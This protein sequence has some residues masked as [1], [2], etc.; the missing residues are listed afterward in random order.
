MNDLDAVIERAKLLLTIEEPQKLAVVQIN[1]IQDLKE[2]IL[3]LMEQVAALS[4]K[5]S[6]QP[7]A[8]A[9]YNCQLPAWPF[10]KELLLNKEVYFM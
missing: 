7:A 8:V 3:L 10:S 9:C 4:A 1:E 5:P 2:L 6:R